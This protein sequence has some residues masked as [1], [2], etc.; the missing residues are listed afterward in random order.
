MSADSAM[1]QLSFSSS[2]STGAMFLVLISTLVVLWKIK[3]GHEYCITG[4]FPYILLSRR[5]G[6]SRWR[7]KREQM[8]QIFYESQ[9]FYLVNSSVRIRYLS[10]MLSY[11]IS[12][13]NNY[14]P[15]YGFCSFSC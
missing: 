11:L 4:Y 10:S 5:R 15:S 7:E 2:R 12:A 13:T 1:F 3:G 9:D 6:V 14:F 8:L